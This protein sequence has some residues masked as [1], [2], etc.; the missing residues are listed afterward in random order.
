[1][2]TRTGS[3]DPPTGLNPELTN[4]GG[5]RDIVRAP[6]ASGPQHTWGPGHLPVPYVASW[7]AETVTVGQILT[8]RPDGS[9]LC[10]QSEEAGDRDRQGVLWTRM[11]YAP[12]AGKPDFSSMHP[13]RQREAMQSLLC[14][15]CGGPASR[16]AC[17]YLFLV[18]GGAG[19]IGD[20]GVLC[21]KPPLCEPCAG[22]AVR[23]CPHLK[24]PV[25]LRVRKPRVWGVIGDQYAPGPRGGLIA[26][27]TDG[28]MPYGHRAG[29][30]F[31]A[32]QL[33]LEL[34][35]CT[36]VPPPEVERSIS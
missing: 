7:S 8:V 9:G 17:G 1:M 12:G 15:V 23:H 4:A 31:L 28:Y 22:L 30:W 6:G 25:A 18:P 5:H 35:R 19:Q 11:T 26:L 27:P 14:Q 10:Y 13:A 2:A 24:N 3:W 33:V 16:T 32:A 20:D 36:R 21:T 29:H 34:E